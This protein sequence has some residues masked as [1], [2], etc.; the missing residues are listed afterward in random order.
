MFVP[1]AACA[2]RL[3]TRCACMGAPVPMTPASLCSCP[4]AHP[5]PFAQPCPPYV[6]VPALSPRQLKML[7]RS[8]LDKDNSAVAATP[9]G[10]IQVGGCCAVVRWSCAWWVLPCRVK[11]F[12][13]GCGRGLHFAL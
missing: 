12:V 10:M 7:A 6:Q 11:G 9:E 3:A 1:H 4:P 13:P 8:S 2:A 5:S